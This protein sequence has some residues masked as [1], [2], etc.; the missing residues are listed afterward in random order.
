[1]E[2][3]IL[4]PAYCPETALI[5]LAD[6]LINQHGFEVVIVNDGSPEQ[7]Y[8]IFS[9]LYA[10]GCDIVV[11]EKNMGKGAAIK[12][13]ISY[14][15]RE[16]KGVTGIITADADGQ[17]LA[18]DILKVSEEL[19]KSQTT[20]VL[21]VRNVS[22]R[23]HAEGVP[24]KSRFGNS[25]S[26]WYF[27]LATGVSCPDTQT[28][29][30]GIPYEM[31]GAA[32]SVEGERYD[33]E[34]NFLTFMAKRKASLSYVNINTV[35]N[36]NN[37]TSH[38]RM[39]RDSYL[40]YK[41]AIRYAISSLAGAVTDLS[42]FALFIY[43]FNHINYF[44][45]SINGSLNIGEYAPALSIVIATIL[46]RVCSGTVNFTLNKNY[47]FR[48]NGMIGGQ[49]GRYICL[50]IFQMLL[51][52]ILVNVFSTGIIPVIIVKIFVDTALFV[53]SFF[54]QSTWV[55]KDNVTKKTA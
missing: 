17:H 46:A 32:L 42:L 29:L 44:N 18:S 27:A 36:D 19:K 35:Y 55:F 24:F 39:F 10:L 25:F 47:S 12:T 5:V 11:H 1:M 51:S 50:F 2:N 49:I 40:I 43:I 21:G 23:D 7:Y 9:E 6:E 14:I 48:S 37:S 16:Y 13:G 34:M 20:L 3:I 26:S 8:D 53:F 45:N 54:A 22:G 52:A 28:G 15:R 30:R 33:Y 41:T 38:F 4:I 31:F